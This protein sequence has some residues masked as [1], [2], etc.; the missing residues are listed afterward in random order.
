MNGDQHQRFLTWL[1]S[2][3][4]SD[5]P[6]DLAVHAYLCTE[7]RRWVAAHDAL[8]TIEPARA[9]LPASQALPDRRV[10]SGTRIRR[11]AAAGAA[12]VA[13]AGIGAL[14]AAQ[15]A[16][17]SADSQ[18][19]G[20]LAATGSPQGSSAASVSAAPTPSR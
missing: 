11:L 4:S 20:V 8:V 5:P 15:L 2:G 16:R 6:R 1:V 14:G 10:A 3:A 7:C 9:A 18:N 19:Q 17:L 12:V 13:L